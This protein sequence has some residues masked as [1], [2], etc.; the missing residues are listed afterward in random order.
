MLN[1]QLS[2]GLPLIPFVG[3]EGF[4]YKFFFHI[5]HPYEM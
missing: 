5:F 2:G 1:P 4:L 3:F